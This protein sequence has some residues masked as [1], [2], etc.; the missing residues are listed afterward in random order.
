MRFIMRLDDWL[1][2]ID[3]SKNGAISIQNLLYPIRIWFALFLQPLSKCW[4]K[5]RDT[6]MRCWLTVTLSNILGELRA[7]VKLQ[8]QRW[9]MPE[10]RGE[11]K[12]NTNFP[13]CLVFTQAQMVMNGPQLLP[14]HSELSAIQVHLL[15]PE[16]WQPST[17]LTL[18]LTNNKLT[19]THR[20]T[21]THTQ[22][23]R[24]RIALN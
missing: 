7:E 21:H 17:S 23:N 14:T 1:D 8:L 24:H 11:V 22:T 13:A 19:H 15:N 12:S 5:N 16:H 9:D 4:S 2:L 10:K 20:H 18:S 6:P 3:W